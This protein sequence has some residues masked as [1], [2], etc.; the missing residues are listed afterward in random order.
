MKYYLDTNICIYFLNG[1]SEKL[2]DRLLSESPRNICIP[3]IVKAELLYG[4][5]KSQRRIENL[6]RVH[7]FL[8]PLQIAGF[9][10]EAAVTYGT[11]RASLE[12]SGTVIGPNDLV[13][14]A[15]VKTADGV[16]VTN[17]TVEFSRVVN[18]KLENWT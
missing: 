3:S 17:N 18:L 15:V 1:S 6:E 7:Q 16:L 8:F 5:E 2:R 13:I 11:M 9:N 10:D 4:A 14:A 12:K